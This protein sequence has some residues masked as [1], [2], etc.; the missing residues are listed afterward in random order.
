MQVILTEKEYKELKAK[1][2]Q[3][4]HISLNELLEKIIDTV[5]DDRFYKIEVFAENGLHFRSDT[6]TY[7]EWTGDGLPFDGSEGKMVEKHYHYE[8]TIKRVEENDK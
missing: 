5:E 1:A 6:R 2:E 7:E 3:Y 8:I 4:D